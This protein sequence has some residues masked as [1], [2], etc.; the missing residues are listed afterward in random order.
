MELVSQ[1]PKDFI[2]IVEL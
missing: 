1:K 2:S